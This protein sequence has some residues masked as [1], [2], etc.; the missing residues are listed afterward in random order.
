MRIR[1]LTSESTVQLDT[2]ED[3]TV[4]GLKKAIKSMFPPCANV[5]DDK[6]LLFYNKAKINAPPETPL[7]DSRVGLSEDSVV[8]V[9]AMS[10]SQPS[11]DTKPKS[12]QE[13]APK[14]QPNQ[15]P[16]FG[17]PSPFGMGSNAGMGGSPNPFAHFENNPESMEKMME[18]MIANMPPE[19][20]ESLRHGAELLKNN[21]EM[22]KQMM[23]MAQNGGFNPMANPQMA[24]WLNMMQPQGGGQMP[25]MASPMMNNQMMPNYGMSPQNMAYNPAMFYQQEP[26]KDGPCFHGFYPPK[27]VNGAPTGQDASAVYASQISTMMDMGY[28]DKESVIKALVE[29][30]GD[31]S[32]A[33]DILHSKK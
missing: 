26:P 31:I 30:K 18:S 15:N 12:T 1:Y 9:V 11:A 7:D 16:G 3:K 33:I 13:Q 8:Y 21:P 25:P 17:G 32:M 5:Q 2:L 6:L 29:A 24:N 20:R 19:Y 23:G 28:S 22:M 14:Q 27:Y 10:S 4:K